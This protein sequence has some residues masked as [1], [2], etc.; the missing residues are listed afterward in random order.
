MKGVKLDMK[1]YFA[2]L[3]I[4]LKMVCLRLVH[5]KDLSQVKG[6]NGSIDNCTGHCWWPA[7][8][9]WHNNCFRR[10]RKC[11][12]IMLLLQIKDIICWAQIHFE[13]SKAKNRKPWSCQFILDG[14]LFL[15]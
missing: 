1:Y 10:W 2:W 3:K 6:I 8:M 9:E 13:S 15:C 5:G 7:D 12:N 11:V 4:Q 14:L